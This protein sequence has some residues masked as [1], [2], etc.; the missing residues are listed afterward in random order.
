MTSILDFYHETSRL[1]KNAEC[2]LAKT[3]K[4]KNSKLTVGYANVVADAGELDRSKN[5][6]ILLG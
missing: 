5:S 6:G 1:L 2:S 3:R 4:I